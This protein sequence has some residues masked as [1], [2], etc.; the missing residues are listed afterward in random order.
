M[1]RVDTENRIAQ[2]KRRKENSFPACKFF[3]IKCNA[4]RCASR[5][6]DY[7]PRLNSGPA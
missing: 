2:Q 5:L 3:K 7:R 6:T 4:L 1:T